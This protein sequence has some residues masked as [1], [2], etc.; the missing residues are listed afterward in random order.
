MIWKRG[1]KRWVSDIGENT[2]NLTLTIT[3]TFS[4]NIVISN[5][6][7]LLHHV[8]LRICHDPTILIF[9]RIS[10]PHFYEGYTH[11][12][13][14][15]HII[16]HNQVI[17]SS[18]VH[19]LEENTCPL[20]LDITRFV[21]NI[22]RT[23]EC[24]ELLNDVKTAVSIPCLCC[25]RLKVKKALWKS[26]CVQMCLHYYVLTFPNVQEVYFNYLIRQT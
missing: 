16:A 25:Y 11:F 3:L 15:Q 7:S 4:V 2:S 18:Q 12:L 21:N 14:L 5:N 22:N 8:F 19:I 20:K 9:N 26:S 10:V 1:E 17:D 24:N 6:I 13:S 23:C